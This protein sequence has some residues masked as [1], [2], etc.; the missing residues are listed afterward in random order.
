MH[1]VRGPD[2]KAEGERGEVQRALRDL[3]D[4]ARRARQAIAPDE[5]Q[6]A[7]IELNS[8][9]GKTPGI[10]VVGDRPDLEID[11][12]V[13]QERVGEICGVVG[14][15]G[16]EVHEEYARAAVARTHSATAGVA[17]IASL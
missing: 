3:E 11:L 17:A 1:D 16:P 15:G 7:G 4:A 9:T 10:E 2:G 13:G 5:I 12:T 8:A 6:Q 14:H